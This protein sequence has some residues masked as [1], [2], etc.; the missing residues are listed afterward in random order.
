MFFLG[1]RDSE[2]RFLPPLVLSDEEAE[3]GM[4]RFEAALKRVKLYEVH[5]L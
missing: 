4:E 2:I 3:L 5:S 1:C